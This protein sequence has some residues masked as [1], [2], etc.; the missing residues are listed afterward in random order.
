MSRLITISSALGLLLACVV[1]RATASPGAPPVPAPG[2]A[3]DQ[4]PAKTAEAPTASDPDVTAQVETPAA[5][6]EPEPA[7]GAETIEI[8]DRAPPGARAELTKEALERD[9]HDDLHKVL[10]GVAGVYLRDEDG[11]GLR[12]NIG[13]RGAAADRSAKVTLMED[14]VLIAPAPYTAPAAYYVPLVTRLSRIEVTKG[15][16]AIRFGP[17]TVGGAID[18]IGEPMPGERAGYVD[19]AGGSDLYGKLHVRAAERRER[20]GVMAE[21]VKLRSD[22]F[23]ELDNRGPTGFD[24][25]DVQL[26]TRLMSEPSAETYHQLDLRAG[27][28]RELSHETYTGLTDADFADE[29]QRRYAGSQLDEMS[30]DHWRLRATHRVDLGSHIR[31]ETAAYRHKF[32]RAWGK[33]DGFVGQRDFY[34]LLAQPTAGANAIYSA[35]LKGEADST[36]PEEQ[37]VLGTNDRH[38]TSQ[39]IQTVIAAEHTTGP[40]AHHIDAGARIHFDRADRRRFED[41]YDMMDGQLVRAQRPRELVLD[42]RAETIALATFA[43]DRVHYKRLEVSAGARLE[44]IDYRFVDH[45][46]MAQREGDYAVFIPGIGAEYHVTD[47][48]SVLAGVHRGFVPVAPSANADVR[49]ESSV[50]Y[51]AGARWRGAS[52]NADLIGFYSDYSNLKGSCTLAAG[53]TEVQEGEEYNGGQVRVWGVEAQVGGEITLDRRRELAL[54]V[55]AAYTLTRSSF[56]HAFASEF[57]GWGMVEQGD[58]LPYLPR[59]QLS[60]SSAVKTPRY[61]LGAAARYQSEGRDVAGQGAIAPA[62]RMAAIFTIDLSAHA[63]LHA[64]AELYATCSNLLDE[65]VIISRRPYG[66][67]PNPPRMFAVGYKARF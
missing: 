54:P 13:M 40:V 12:P 66:A 48:A 61:E 49:P 18:L 33:V 62:E 35:I 28:G 23:K 25:D 6:P 67:R 11:Y 56:Q 3:P 53:C 26:T 44:L 14:G 1:P 55:A 64:L 59:H 17:N 39:G 2:P 9:E 63:R 20:W 52:I 8:V 42:S 32:Q 60:L 19:I 5:P 10:R 43:E 7:S 30:W 27:Y 21:Y 58:E 38:F 24:K 50:N 37:L 57:G 16:S 15:P 65:Q 45:Q 51:E 41:A 31:I 22:G 4:S 47:E 36:S 46:T 34:Q 29:P